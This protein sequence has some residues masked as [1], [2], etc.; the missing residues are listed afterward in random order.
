[1]TFNLIFGTVYLEIKDEVKEMSVKYELHARNDE[2]YCTL[3]IEPEDN[4]VN[5]TVEGS[6]RTNKIQID[7]APVRMKELCLLIS[8]LTAI[9]D[10]IS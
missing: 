8:V 6:H 2:S 1:M 7:F 3:T 9:K 5:I 10:E 4:F